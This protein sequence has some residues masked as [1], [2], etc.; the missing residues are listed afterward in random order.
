VRSIRTDLY[1]RHRQH[2]HPPRCRIPYDPAPDVLS[3]AAPDAADD[4]DD[5][6]RDA[7]VCTRSPNK[8]Q[9]EH[10][11]GSSR[12]ASLRITSKTPQASHR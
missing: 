8:P 9:R 3:G 11:A 2:L 7:D 5:K 12:S 4:D 10:G 1:H 6:S